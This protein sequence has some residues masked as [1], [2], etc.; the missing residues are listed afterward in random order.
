MSAFFY[1][2]A[3]NTKQLVIY[4]APAYFIFMLNYC[5]FE[6]DTKTH[7][8]K[9]IK[10]WPL[11]KLGAVVVATFAITY[12]PFFRSF[13]DIMFF[14]TGGEHS[15]YFH[16]CPPMSLRFCALLLVLRYIPHYRYAFESNFSVLAMLLTG[17][18]VSVGLKNLKLD[19]FPFMMFVSG[20]IFYHFGIYVHD[21]HAIYV[22]MPYM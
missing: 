6:F 18:M 21:K 3:L 11:F 15:P 13:G 5:C 10:F 22:L 16:K 7:S 9:R 14:L 1:C 12:I 17:F 19:D 2:I 8:F 20:S 4:Y